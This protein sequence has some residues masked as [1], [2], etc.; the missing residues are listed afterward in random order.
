MLIFDRREF[1]EILKYWSTF[2]RRRYLVP[3]NTVVKWMVLDKLP[4][5]KDNVESTTKKFNNYHYD[6]INFITIYHLTFIM[7]DL[8]TSLGNTVNNNSYEVFR[9]KFKR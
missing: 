5:F 8:V 7:S 4:P 3:G 1:L 2:G 6:L 9:D